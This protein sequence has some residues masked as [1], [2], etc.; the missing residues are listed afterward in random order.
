MK[1]HTLSFYFLCIFFMCN[2]CFCTKTHAYYDGFNALFKNSSPIVILYELAA[3]YAASDIF[4][5]RAYTYSRDPSL[6][7]IITCFGTGFVAMAITKLAHEL[8]H[9]ASGWII[10]GR[11]AHIKFGGNEELIKTYGI[12][13]LPHGSLSI[14]GFNPCRGY[15][16]MPDDPRSGNWRRLIVKMSGGLAGIAAA[17]AVKVGVYLWLNR[18]LLNNRPL[19]TL[20]EACKN[21]CSLDSITIRNLT[22]MFW[23]FAEENDGAYWRTFFGMNKK[24]SRSFFTC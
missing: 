9:A 14:T 12:F 17:F 7:Q 11:D 19:T 21:S 20:K 24:H 2:Q 6:S 13:S 1:A 15:T 16:L 18:T 23:P 3:I 10:E 22:D 5:G 8:G 4:V